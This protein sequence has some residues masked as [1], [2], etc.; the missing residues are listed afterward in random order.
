M[1][2]LHAHRERHTHPTSARA[3]LHPTATQRPDNKFWKVSAQEYFLHNG[4]IEK[5]TQNACQCL[6]TPYQYLV[7]KTLVVKTLVVKT[8][9]V[10]TLQRRLFRMRA[11]A[12]AVPQSM[13][14]SFVTTAL[15][16]SWCDMYVCMYDVCM[17]DIYMYA[18]LYMYTVPQSMPASFVTTAL[19][20][21]WYIHEYIST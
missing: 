6:C 19:Y 4:T 2:I 12:S 5:T 3:C 8:L 21:S 1:Y 9:V 16:L 17:Y 10:K 14:A 18:C 7:V 15:Y 13:P 11:N 20:L